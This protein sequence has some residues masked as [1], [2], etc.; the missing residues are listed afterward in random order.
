MRSRGELSPLVSVIIAAVLIVVGV[1]LIMIFYHGAKAMGQHAINTPEVEV[2][3]SI[4]ASTGVVTINIY[5]AGTTQLTVSGVKVYGPN[6]STLSCSWSGV[7]ATVVAGGSYGLV[8]QCS[9]VEPGVSYTVVV[10]LSGAGGSL[11]ESLTLT[12][13]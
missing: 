8:G 2:S 12:A 5:N 3:G 6:G 1:A 7:G 4:S 13:S 11:V 10:S 9:G